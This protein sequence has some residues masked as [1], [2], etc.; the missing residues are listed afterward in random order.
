MAQG[1]DNRHIRMVLLAAFSILGV[2][3]II[4]H[5][6][7]FKTPSIKKQNDINIVPA[8]TI[9]FN[10]YRLSDSV[11]PVLVSKLKYMGSEQDIDVIRENILSESVDPIWAQEAAKSLDLAFKQISG[12]S[13]LNFDCRTNGCEV[14]G[15]FSAIS[16][17]QINSQIKQLDLANSS[18]RNKNSTLSNKEFSNSYKIR[19]VKPLVVQFKTNY[20]R[21]R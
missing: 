13:D 9:N 16:E 3:S 11:K 6:T 4:F 21:N 17:A 20:I 18:L 7:V 14:S 10:N 1:H 5:N 8:S 2:C 12:F 19:S 15:T